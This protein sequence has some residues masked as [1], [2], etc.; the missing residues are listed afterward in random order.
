MY[1]AIILNEC[2]SSTA[3]GRSFSTDHT[4]STV[5]GDTSASKSHTSLA[6]GYI[7]KDCSLHSQEKMDSFITQSSSSSLS[8]Q[9]AE[10]SSDVLFSSSSSPFTS[11]YSRDRSR[12]NKTGEKLMS[13]T[14][15]Q[16]AVLS[17]NY[18]S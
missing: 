13:W 14:E 7:C 2:N 16:I 9:A 15:M 8:S 1:F 12:R 11:I 10:A 18:W 5:N 4:S 17:H 3:T 6:N